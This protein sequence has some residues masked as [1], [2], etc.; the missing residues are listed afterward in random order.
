MTSS[1]FQC[2]PRQGDPVHHAAVAEETR[3]SSA[4]IFGGFVIARNPVSPPTLADQMPQRTTMHGLPAAF[5]LAHIAVAL[6]AVP[7]LARS[8]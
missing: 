3:N 6:A 1:A 7:A 4:M 2:N 8:R 5:T